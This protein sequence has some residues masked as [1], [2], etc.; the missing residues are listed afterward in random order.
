MNKLKGA[1]RAWDEASDFDAA[2]DKTKFRRYE[3]ACDRVKNFYKEQHGKLRLYT[4]SSGV[5]YNVLADSKANCRVQ[6]QG[7]RG[8]QED[9]SSANG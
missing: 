7:S 3:D 6:H 8:I 4:R 5:K 2:K 1:E 9:R